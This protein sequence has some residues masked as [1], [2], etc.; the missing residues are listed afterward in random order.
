M[1]GKKAEE[2]IRVG[3]FKNLIHAIIPNYHYFFDFQS[4]GIWKSNEIMS[5]RVQVIVY[6]K[7]V[8]KTDQKTEISGKS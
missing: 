4:I 6:T 1:R 8:I 3:S 5:E 7:L 2:K